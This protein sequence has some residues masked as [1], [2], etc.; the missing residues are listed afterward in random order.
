ML[1]KILLRMNFLKDSNV[2]LNMILLILKTFL[3]NFFSFLN[4]LTSDKFYIT[5]VS[6][7]GSFDTCLLNN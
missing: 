6:Y 7:L 4:D 1:L 5:V 2:F 3:R